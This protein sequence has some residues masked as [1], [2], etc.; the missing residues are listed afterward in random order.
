MEKYKCDKCGQDVPSDD[1]INFTIF[2]GSQEEPP[3]Y[4]IACPHCHTTNLEL[5][6]KIYCD[7]CGDVIVKDDGE[8]CEECRVCKLES[9]KDKWAEPFDTENP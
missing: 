4:G 2:R 8:I 5:I 6:E 7:C 3:E 1:L 9:D